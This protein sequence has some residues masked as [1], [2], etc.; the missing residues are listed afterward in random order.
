MET[1]PKMRATD[2]ATL[3]R[4]AF[5]AALHA[6]SEHYHQKHPFHLRNSAVKIGSGINKVINERENFWRCHS[7]LNVA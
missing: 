7:N 5:I 2:G 6:Q 4:D 1:V 3:T